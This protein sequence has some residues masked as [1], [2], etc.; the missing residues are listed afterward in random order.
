MTSD[1][2]MSIKSGENGASVNGIQ[3]EI[4]VSY[5]IVAS[6]Y[7]RMGYDCVMTSCTDYVAGRHP[8]SKHPQGLAIDYRINHIPEG[9]R[10]MLCDKVAA[11]LGDQYDVVLKSD[12]L[13]TE[14]DPPELRGTLE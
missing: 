14:F 9:I 10:Q 6:V 2:F 8:R 5:P 1:L 12:H 3:P 7:A 11:A 4:A 13:H